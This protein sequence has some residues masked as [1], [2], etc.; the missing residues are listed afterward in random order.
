[1]RMQ[2]TEAVCW[3]L[4]CAGSDVVSCA[5]HAS[6]VACRCVLSMCVRTVQEGKSGDFPSTQHP[7]TPVLQSLSR[8]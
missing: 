8:R 7:F 6:C 5:S 4:C 1:M 3:K 2:H